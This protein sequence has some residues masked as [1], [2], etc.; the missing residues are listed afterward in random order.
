M[1]GP[2][3]GICSL[4][5]AATNGYCRCFFIKLDVLLYLI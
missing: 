2:T 1:E 4:I 3:P 5:H